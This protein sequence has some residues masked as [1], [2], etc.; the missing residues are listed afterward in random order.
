MPAPTI[1]WLQWLLRNS[2]HL[3]LY[4]KNSSNKT[5]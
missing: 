2:A 4:F 1:R 3:V 5:D